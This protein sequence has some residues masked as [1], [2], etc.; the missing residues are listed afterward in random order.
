MALQSPSQQPSPVTENA[1][2]LQVGYS[3]YDHQGPLVPPGEQ[4]QPIINVDLPIITYQEMRHG[5]IQ[6]AAES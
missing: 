3:F 4:T 6:S 1:E 2:A 5:L